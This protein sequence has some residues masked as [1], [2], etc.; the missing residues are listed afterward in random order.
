[1][2]QATRSSVTPGG[3]KMPRVIRQSTGIPDFLHDA[4]PF[5]D[6]VSG[7]FALQGMCSSSSTHSAR[8]LPPR[9]CPT[10]SIGLFTVESTWLPISCTATSPPPWNRM[11]VSLRPA[12]FS[13]ATVMIWSSCFEPAPAILKAL[14][15]ATSTAS[16]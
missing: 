10:A 12:A 1:M 8:S 11:S 3:M 5:T 6:V 4:M 9:Q 2:Y 13:S 7:I 16:R 15:G 14:F